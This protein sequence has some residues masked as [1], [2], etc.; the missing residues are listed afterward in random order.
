M[1]S[2]DTI[3]HYQRA[4]LYAVTPYVNHL[5]ILHYQR[6]RLY[7]VTRYVNHLAVITSYTCRFTVA[8]LTAYYT[9]TITGSSYDRS[10]RR[11]PGW[12]GW[13]NRSD[14]HLCF[15]MVYG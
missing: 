8:C 10:S 1:L 9:I 14:K 4:L 3:L 2:T 6:A 11:V 15:G 12:D 13:L 5:A 7:A